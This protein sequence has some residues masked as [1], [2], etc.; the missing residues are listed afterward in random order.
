[1]FLVSIT[2]WIIPY[3]TSIETAERFTPQDYQENYAV[4]RTSLSFLTAFNLVTSLHGSFPKNN[5]DTLNRDLIKKRACTELI[6]AG[7]EEIYCS[8]N[9]MLLN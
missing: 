7:P 2:S 3:L 1:M 8:T 4:A 5:M 9:Y 6:S